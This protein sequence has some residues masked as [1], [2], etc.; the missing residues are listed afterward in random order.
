MAIV[1]IGGVSTAAHVVDWW[2]PL[3][4][5]VG[6]LKR[7]PEAAPLRAGEIISTGTLTDAHPVA[8]GETWRTEVTGFR[9]LTLAFS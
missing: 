3:A 2:N 1:E 6:L 9:G 8:P 7:Q 4:F 5:L